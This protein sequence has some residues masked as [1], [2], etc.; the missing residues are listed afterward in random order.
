MIYNLAE[1]DRNERTLID[2]LDLTRRKH[3]PEDAT[4]EDLLAPIFRSGK[5]VYEQPS[6]GATRL[7]AQKQLDSFH[8][9]VKRFLNPHEYPVG[10]SPS[11]YELRTKLILEARGENP[12]HVIPVEHAEAK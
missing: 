6:I 9:G 8:P 5:L 2:P 4:Y 10:L 3:I 12:K 7:R 11:L 1:P